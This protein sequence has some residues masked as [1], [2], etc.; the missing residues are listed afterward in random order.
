MDLTPWANGSTVKE[1]ALAWQRWNKKERSNIV[2]STS[3]WPTLSVFSTSTWPQNVNITEWVSMFIEY[4]KGD[5]K[6]RWFASLC[7][8]YI[9]NKKNLNIL[10]TN[11]T[12]YLYLHQLVYGFVLANVTH[13]KSLMWVYENE[14]W[15]ECCFW[16]FVHRFVYVA[17]AT[18]HP[19]GVV[20]G[21][22]MVIRVCVATFL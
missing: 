4:Q 19:K 1:G 18:E 12:I 17:M 22:L 14:V 10:E 2:T 13:I 8:I 6:M 11:Y 15:K 7:L 3:G 9:A 20:K 16:R 21:P 5:A